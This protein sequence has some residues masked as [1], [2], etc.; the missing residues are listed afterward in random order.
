MKSLADAK[1]LKRAWR[2]QL[3]TTLVAFNRVVLGPKY[4]G[5]AKMRR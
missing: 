2:G 5:G 3:W 4:I 1:A